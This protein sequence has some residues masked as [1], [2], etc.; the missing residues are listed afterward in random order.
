VLVA[1]QL[2]SRIIL[3]DDFVDSVAR[4]EPVTCLAT[5]GASDLRSGGWR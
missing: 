1:K 2:L 5:L 3:I 4:P